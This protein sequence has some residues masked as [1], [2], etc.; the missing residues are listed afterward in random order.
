MRVTALILGILGGLAAAALGVLWFSDSKWCQ[1]NVEKCKLAGRITQAFESSSAGDA[2]GKA[3]SKVA[4]YENKYL[5]ERATRGTTAYVLM[6]CL[7]LGVVGGILGLK[8]KGKIA[9]LVMLVGPI[10]GAVMVPVSL[11]GSGLLALGGILAFFAK[12]KWS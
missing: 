3:D 11:I 12:P 9:S 7:L 10:A 1:E 4:E 6:G 8:G 5:K 2:M